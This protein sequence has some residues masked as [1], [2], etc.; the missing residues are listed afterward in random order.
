MAAAGPR[1]AGPG[2]VAPALAVLA[3][4]IR[5]QRQLLPERGLEGGHAKWACK[6][7][8]LLVQEPIAPQLIDKGLPSS[9]LAAHVL[10][11]RQEDSPFRL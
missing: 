1:P 3:T 2:G 11:S 5:Q 7:C 4:V 6:C 10:V 8:Q 9:G